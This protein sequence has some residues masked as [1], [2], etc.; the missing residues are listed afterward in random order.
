[1]QTV[2]MRWTVIYEGRPYGP[3]EAVSVPDGLALSLGMMAGEIVV[4]TPDVSPDVDSRAAKAA[5]KADAPASQPQEVAP[6]VAPAPESPR[7]NS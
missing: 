6:V 3:G 5:V 7:P 1:M 4:V 2:K